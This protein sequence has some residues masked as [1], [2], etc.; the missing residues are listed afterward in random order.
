MKE[1]LSIPTM[2][3]ELTDDNKEVR[4]IL[5]NLIKEPEHVKYIE[6]LYTL[7]IKGN[8]IIEI[9]DKTN[10]DYKKFAESL[11]QLICSAQNSQLM[12]TLHEKRNKQKN[13]KVI[14]IMKDGN[15]KAEHIL[16]KIIEDGHP[17]YIYKLN[18]LNLWG[19]SIVK[20]WNYTGK[21]LLSFYKNIDKLID[22]KNKKIN[23]FL[24]K[25]PLLTDNYED[26]F[27]HINY[28]DLD[29]SQEEEYDVIGKKNQKVKVKIIYGDF[30]SKKA[31]EL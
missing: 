14:K 21:N 26:E 30:Q 17:E 22:R 11:S 4:E 9:W 12:K 28:D 10:K 2:I 20:L 5:L 24:S 3:K 1:R 6:Y 8:L 25:Q 23:R 27:Y 13:I 19:I 29:L 16:N 31:H 7:E 18:D 15:E